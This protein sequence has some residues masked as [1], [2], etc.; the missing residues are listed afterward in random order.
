MTGP[1]EAQRSSSRPRVS[2]CPVCLRPAVRAALLA[3]AALAAGAALL[4][5]ATLAACGDSDRYASVDGSGVT[6][7]VVMVEK[8]AAAGAAPSPLPS[9]RVQISDMKTAEYITEVKTDAEGRFTFGVGPGRYTIKAILPA[10][11][12]LV[13]PVIATVR[14]GKV[15]P[16]TISAEPPLPSASP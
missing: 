15:T 11:E 7:R 10:G 6:G 8:G 12:A 9:V 4:A 16:V 1:R 14:R 5:C 3:C 13:T 2:A